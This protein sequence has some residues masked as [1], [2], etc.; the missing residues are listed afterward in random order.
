M[1][2]LDWD[3]S[4][5]MDYAVMKQVIQCEG[6]REVWTIIN[7]YNDSVFRGHIQAYVAFERG[8]I[9]DHFWLKKNTKIIDLSL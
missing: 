6:K 2:E 9:L 7:A 4:Q 1:N 3:G 5:D 8:N